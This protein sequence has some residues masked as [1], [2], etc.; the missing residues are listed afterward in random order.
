MEEQRTS[1]ISAS[2][3]RCLTTFIIFETD[4]LPE[5]AVRR[6]VHTR[7]K[8]IITSMRIFLLGAASESDPIAESDSN[9][10]VYCG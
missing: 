4:E 7:T 5:H 1:I 3:R 9:P 8:W 10:D 6:T 2:S